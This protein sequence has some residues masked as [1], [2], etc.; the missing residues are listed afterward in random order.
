MM[1]FS[2]TVRVWRG[3][4]CILLMLSLNLCFG[5]ESP[6]S[7]PSYSASSFADAKFQNASNRKPIPETLYAVA[8]ILVS[9]GRDDEAE[10]ILERLVAEHPRFVPAYAELAELQM[11]DRRL[12]DAVETLSAGLEIAQEEPSLLN[13]VGMCWMLRDQHEKA[14]EYFTR[15]AAL[16]PDDARYRA[17]VAAALGMQGRYDES[18]AVYQQVVSLAEAHYNLG[19]LAEA[20]EDFEHAT[21]HFTAARE[22][23]PKLQRKPR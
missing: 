6:S 13:N 11:R 14:L 4:T 10:P 21:I 19:V 9:Q 22:L 3:M 8:R 18:L 20:R 23:N 12:G 1:A 2:Q 7:H 15:A 17:N 16:A 5:C